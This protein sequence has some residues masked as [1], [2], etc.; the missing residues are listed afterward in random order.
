MKY[1]FIFILLL[2]IGSNIYAQKYTYKVDHGYYST[3]EQV[4]NLF[5]YQQNLEVDLNYNVILD[6]TN[7]LLTIYSYNEKLISFDIADI[8][9]EGNKTIIQSAFQTT[10]I[11][12]STYI[13]LYNADKKIVLRVTRVLLE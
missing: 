6:K 9:Q 12:T 4:N 8:Q 2:F 10:I 11:L 5:S 1:K 7:R 3:L 13:T